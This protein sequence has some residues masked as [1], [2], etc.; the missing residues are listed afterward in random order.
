MARQDDVLATVSASAPRRFFAMGVLGALGVLLIYIA[1]SSPPASVGWQIF[2]IAFGAFSVWAAV[3]L[4]KATRH[5]V[6]LTREEL[7]ESSGRVL[8]R[9]EDITDVSRGVFAM[10]PSNGFLLRVKGGGP[11][12]WAPGLWWRV[13]GRVGV[14]GVTAASQAK[15]MSEII[16]AMLAERA[17]ASGANAFTEALMAARNAPSPQ[18]DAEPDPDMPVDER[19]TA[20]LLG[21]LSMRDPDDWHEVALNYDFARSV[22]PLRWMLA[23]PS[24]DRATVATL[25]WRAM[26]EQAESAV[27]DA[28]LS[29]I[30]GQLVAGGYGRAEIAFAGHSEAD[31]A[32]VEARAQAAGLPTPLPDWFWQAR[33]GRDLS[34]ERYTEG[35]PR[36]MVEWAYPDQPER[37]GD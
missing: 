2:L 5:V 34:E 31:R 4:G 24:C 18:A 19:I 9:V 10:K 22:E 25:F 16:A 20:G 32:E 26:S 15:M 33:G 21:W 1:F 14:G 37:W 27:S 12:A 11:R 35:L 6:E 8:C 30:A 36:P 23:Q 28:I 29:A 17:G 3:V 13:A 7:R